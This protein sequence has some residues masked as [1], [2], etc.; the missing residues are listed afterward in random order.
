MER[1]VGYL[2]GGGASK[3][4]GSVPLSTAPG[5]SRTSTWKTEK[6]DKLRLVAGTTTGAIPAGA[7]A[8]AGGWGSQTGV[9][10]DVT[11][12]R[13]RRRRVTARFYRIIACS[14]ALFLLFAYGTAFWRIIQVERAIKTMRGQ[15]AA[16]EKRNQDLHQQLQSASDDAFVEQTAREE[17]G[18]VKPGETAWVVVTPEDP[19]N[20]YRVE[21]RST[22]NSVVDAEGW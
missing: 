4:H 22:H 11:R 2:Q 18:L 16:A 15:V 7:G 12:V 8:M 3:P 5:Q 10:A 13:R 21:P 6:S 9:P 20:P 1:R 19:H 17:L 14:L